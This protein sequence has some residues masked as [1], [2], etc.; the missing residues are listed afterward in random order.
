MRALLL[1]LVCAATVLACEPTLQQESGVVLEID[2]PSL[3]RVDS[4]VL[5][6][7]EG[8]RLTFDTTELDFRPEFPAP[9]LAEHRVIGDTIVVTYKT[10]GD[11]LVVTQLDDRDH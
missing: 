11:R 1:S 5:L 9:H 6:T 10:D 8:E 7:R 2:S 3:G 4:F